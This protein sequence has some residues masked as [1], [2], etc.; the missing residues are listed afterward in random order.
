MSLEDLANSFSNGRGSYNKHQR[1]TNALVNYLHEET[2]V[3]GVF[4]NIE[5]FKTNKLGEEYVNGELD[6]LAIYE[7][8]VE[9]Y[10][11]KSRNKDNHHRKSR[12]QFK[13]EIELVANNLVGCSIK[14][15]SFMPN[16]FKEMRI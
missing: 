13:N 16:Y 4:T 11:V 10:N 12:K 8:R 9:V 14:Y 1:M 6:V 3:L 15:F 7:D 5:L 2:N